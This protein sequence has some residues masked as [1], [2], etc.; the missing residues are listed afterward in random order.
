MDPP[1]LVKPNSALLHDPRACWYLAW[2]T[3][4]QEALCDTVMIGRQ[5]EPVFRR[6]VRSH[7]L[8]GH[9]HGLWVP[10]ALND[11]PCSSLC[12]NCPVLPI[13]HH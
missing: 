6:R 7:G 5:A 12:L 13:L 2:D 10:V 8:P 9:Y 3:L 11:G 4:Y 1:T